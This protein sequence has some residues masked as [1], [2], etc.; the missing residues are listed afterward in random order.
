MVITIIPSDRR[1]LPEWNWVCLAKFRFGGSRVVRYGYVDIDDFGE[2]D[3]PAG[4]LG[5]E[6]LEL[7]DG[8]VEGALGAGLVA[9]GVV[10][11]VG[12]GGIAAKD[13]G[14]ADVGQEGIVV[15]AHPLIEVRQ[16]HLEEAGFHGAAAAEAPGGHGELFEEDIP[17]GAGG[18][19]LGAEF[20]AE[21]IEAAFVFAGQGGGL[22]GEAV[23]EGIGGDLALALGGFGA[24]AFL[25]VP[26]V[27]ID[28][29]LSS[30]EKRFLMV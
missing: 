21:P 7:V 28:L 14:V 27:G 2:R 19:V 23:T 30:H 11:D 10:D 15:I 20:G 8:A 9:A 22:G 24:G 26:A 1:L 29:F 4:A 17:G 12:F 25:G 16:P 13:E 3:I 5:L 6:A 18:L